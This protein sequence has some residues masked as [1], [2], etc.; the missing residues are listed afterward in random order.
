MQSS[1]YQ[2]RKSPHGRRVSSFSS[3]KIMKLTRVI[4]HDD[5]IKQPRLIR[6]AFSNFTDF[7]KPSMG[8][9]LQRQSTYTYYVRGNPLTRYRVEHVSVQ[10][11]LSYNPYGY[12]TD[13]LQMLTNQTLLLDSVV[14]VERVLQPHGLLRVFH[15]LKHEVLSPYPEPAKDPEDWIMY[16]PFTAQGIQSVYWEE[17]LTGN[18]VPEQLLRK[19]QQ[20]LKNHV[21]SSMEKLRSPTTVSAAT[22]QTAVNGSSAGEA[23]AQLHAAARLAAALPVTALQQLWREV[24]E[25]EKQVLL[26]V[27]ASSGSGPAGSLVLRQLTPMR[28]VGSAA[29]PKTQHASLLLAMAS[30]IP[31]PSLARQLIQ[32]LHSVDLEDDVIV[33]AIVYV[34]GAKILKGMCRNATMAVPYPLYGQ[35]QCPLDYVVKNFADYLLDRIK[36]ERGGWTTRATLIQ[37]YATLGLHVNTETLAMIGRTDVNRIARTTAI[38]ALSPRY[39]DQSYRQKAMDIVFLNAIDPHM[40]QE[41]RQSSLVVL[42]AWSPEQVYWNDLALYTWSLRSRPVARLIYSFMQS[43]ANNPAMDPI[44][45]TYAASALL[46]ARPIKTP[47]ESSFSF[48]WSTAHAG[49]QLKLEGHHGWLKFPP[50]ERA[51]QMYRAVNA[52]A[53]HFDFNIFEMATGFNHY[54]GVSSVMDQSESVKHGEAEQSPEMKLLLKLFTSEVFLPVDFA[55]FGIGPHSSC[56]LC[57]LLWYK[58]GPCGTGEVHESLHF[59]ELASVEAFLPN[60]MGLPVLAELLSPTVL[61]TNSSVSGSSCRQPFTGNFSLNTDIKLVSKVNSVLR[62]MVPWLG[63]SLAV[64]IDTEKTLSLPLQL[65][66]SFE[67]VYKESSDSEPVHGRS[68]NSARLREQD[69]EEHG[70]QWTSRRASYR[71]DEDGD[72]SYQLPRRLS[73][74][75]DI[76]PSRQDEIPVVFVQTVPLIV[77]KPLRPGNDVTKLEKLHVIRNVNT[78]P[79]LQTIDLGSELTGNKISLSYEGDSS[80]PFSYKKIIDFVRSPA[81]V[82]TLLGARDA[83]FER[84]VLSLAPAT[85]S[86]TSVLLTLDTSGYTPIDS[87]A[88]QGTECHINNEGQLVC[89][90]PAKVT[91]TAQVKFPSGSSM[92]TELTLY[93]PALLDQLYNSSL[94]A[95]T[96]QS[97]GKYSSKVQIL[98]NLTRPVPLSLPQL[99]EWLAAERCLNASASLAVYTGQPQPDLPADFTLHAVA[100]LTPERSQLLQRKAQSACAAD[101]LEPSVALDGLAVYDLID[102]TTTNPGNLSVFL[103]PCWR[104]IKNHLFAV[105]YPN[106]EPVYA[107]SD[108]DTSQSAALHANRSLLTNE[109]SAECRFCSPNWRAYDLKTPRNI[110]TSIFA[111][112]KQTDFYNDHSNHLDMTGTP[113]E[114]TGDAWVDIDTLGPQT[115][116]N[117]HDSDSTTDSAPQGTCFTDNGSIRTADGLSFDK[118]YT[119]CYQL[120]VA[121]CNR[122]PKWYVFTHLDPLAGRADT[123]SPFFRYLDANFDVDVYL[124]Y[125]TL[126]I[127]GVAPYRNTGVFPIMHPVKKHAIGLCSSINNGD[128]ISCTIDGI[129]RLTVGR[130]GGNVTLLGDDEVC[131]MCGNNNGDPTDDNIGAHMCRYSDLSLMAASWTK[132]MSCP[133]VPDLEAQL[134]LV[135]EYQNGPKC[136]RAGIPIPWKF[137]EFP[138]L[139]DAARLSLSTPGISFP[140]R[141]DEPKPDHDSSSRPFPIS[142]TLSAVGEDGRQVWKETP[143]MEENYPHLNP[144]PSTFVQPSRKQYPTRSQWASQGDPLYESEIVPEPELPAQIASELDM[145][146]KQT[147]HAKLSAN[148]DDTDDCI[149][150]A[151]RV[152]Q[153]YTLPVEILVAL[154][155]TQLCDTKKYCSMTEGQLV[156]VNAAKYKYYEAPPDVYHAMRWG[157]MTELPDTSGGMLTT[158]EQY[159]AQSCRK[160]DP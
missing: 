25:D 88:G 150:T 128:L 37:T 116:H 96:F 18:R 15:T 104:A 1:R 63:S 143:E 74:Q 23:A 137:P 70:A 123:R 47:L 91:V 20:D 54:P 56:P 8:R 71:D 142:Y 90:Y 79:I 35:Q 133:W 51:S 159:V 42:L 77:I 85:E 58:M 6:S 49:K 146:V 48:Q 39:L 93:Q 69:E 84:S 108:E 67:K 122:E 109:W 5:C 4:D 21:K 152:E 119:S 114:S 155:A 53:G 101:L 19:Y 141:P 28:S 111:L 62:V 61:Y 24:A 158:M 11:F 115:Y 55:K 76:R 103:T 36:S 149:I 81:E 147:P 145:S 100:G 72:K 156:T 41:E 38:Y 89:P 45:S 117:S 57:E 9:G 118:V 3:D 112:A 130:V 92:S 135:Q 134:K 13:Q 120:A 65:Q 16:T 52:A 14:H 29:V 82:V 125:R 99:S 151:Y 34:S 66:G 83:K 107:S 110:E 127:N 40:G 129:V 30:N 86:S 113:L 7:G 59:R 153:T 97:S 105:M 64:G 43:V 10:G 17:A 102:V 95:I 68:V 131:G 33:G 87:L 136:S 46:L 154:N 78:E 32:Y 60:E 80:S 2:G 12:K 75:L 31:D 140:V 144:E 126:S 106:V 124:G 22:E 73:L 121:H 148:T 98:G 44:Q 138:D 94:M 139:P 160:R 50:A 132:D 26:E 157:Y 27:F